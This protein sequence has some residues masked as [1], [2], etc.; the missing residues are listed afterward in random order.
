MEEKV[1]SS[2]KHNENIDFIAPIRLLIKKKTQLEKE[3]LGAIDTFKDD[4]DNFK[5][6]LKVKTRTTCESSNS[7]QEKPIKKVKFKQKIKD[8]VV[9]TS[10]KNINYNSSYKSF[11][12]KKKKT[13]EDEQQSCTCTIF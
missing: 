12:N 10:Y 9:V 8:V 5:S 11:N 7:S 3:S 13:D 1:E 4:E 6:C 2:S